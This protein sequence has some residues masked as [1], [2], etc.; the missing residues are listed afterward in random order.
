MRI[1]R[2]LLPYVAVA[3]LV[4][5]GASAI[6]LTSLG[7]VSSVGVA[8]ADIARPQ[9]ALTLSATGRL[10]YFRQEQSGDLTLWVA[11]F[12][13]T[14]ARPLGTLPGSG[15]RPFTTRWTTDGGAIA[16]INAGIAVSA[17]RIDGSRFDTV[18]S[19]DARSAGFR[20]IDHRWSPSGTKVAVT[21]VRSSDNRSDVFL[22]SVTAPT[23]ARATDLGDAFAAEWL[24]DERVLVES[25]RGLLGTVRSGFP[26]KRLTERVGASPVFVDGR[27]FFLAGK[28]GGPGDGA[29]PYVAD[30]SVWSVDAEGG[31]GRLE[32]RLGLGGELRLDGRWPDG[33]YLVHVSRDRTQWLAGTRLITLPSPIPL[34]RV[35]VSADRRA[36]IG[37]GGARIMRI[38]V[39]RSSLASP[40]PD[41]FVVLLDGVIGAD[42]W[43]PRGP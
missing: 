39:A 26:L 9:G 4:A 3:L 37:L 10:A 22:A 28:V 19:A 34:Q 17:I 38:D 11:N 20:I 32:M 42:A 1:I 30:T 6:V 41:A 7:S 2:G 21:A 5:I 31:E 16:F 18:L 15:P 29:F 35:V 40:P 36:A 14:R 24:D 23:F 8:P 27:V 12:D 33:R 43:V 25:S 13:G